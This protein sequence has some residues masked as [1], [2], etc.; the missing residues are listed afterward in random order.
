MP[1]IV[2]IV[3]L[4]AFIAYALLC[5]AVVFI[6][7]YIFYGAYDYPANINNAHENGFNAEEVT[8]FDYGKNGGKVTAWMY[9]N[10]TLQNNGKVIVFLH[11]NSY[12]L[13]H[14]YHKM[15]PLANAGYSVLMPEYRGFGGQGRKIKQKYL[16]Q[17]A[18]NAVKYLNGI[19]FSNEN[20]IVYGMSLGTYMA[21]YAAESLQNN[22]NFNAVILE[23]PFTSL[24]ETAGSY[25]TFGSIKTVPLDLLMKDTYNNSALIDKIKTRILIMATKNDKVIPPALAKKLYE[26]ALQPKKMIFYDG[27]SHDGLYSVGNY[28]DILEWL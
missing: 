3:V 10:N 17:D 19:G 23:V 11:G 27:A 21:L 16:E 18:V 15:I 20:I 5:A 6:P 24:S 8:Y 2:K 7:E 12:N 25:V 22:G 4:T 26:Q 1:K 14:Y 28:R 9:L 13:E